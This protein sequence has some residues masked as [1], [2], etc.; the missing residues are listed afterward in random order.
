MPWLTPARAPGA[1]LTSSVG[2]ALLPPVSLCWTT[3]PARRPCP[4]VWTRCGK[5]AAV[6]LSWT[7]S[8]SGGD[9]AVAPPGAV[10]GSCCG[11][12]TRRDQVISRRTCGRGHHRQGAS[13]RSGARDGLPYPLAPATRIRV[14]GEREEI[15]IGCHV[16]GKIVVWALLRAGS[17]PLRP[18][19]A[20]G[21][22]PAPPRRGGFVIS[23]GRPL[24]R[25]GNPPFPFPPPSALS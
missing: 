20:V 19:V 12:H 4:G 8:P 11:G 16:A 10:S 1:A 5:R 25:G 23:P 7:R 18:D 21:D 13:R 24:C 15:V 6:L 3:G 17:W 9:T 22:T 2:V 14:V